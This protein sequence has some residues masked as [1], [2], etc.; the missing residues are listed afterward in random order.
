M[1]AVQAIQN[2]GMVKIAFYVIVA[3]IVIYYI[4]GWYSGSTNDLVLSNTKIPANQSTTAV[5]STGGSP[6]IRSGGA[7]TLS[8]W[9]YINSYEY[10][11]G[12]PK[13]VFTIYDSKMP[14]RALVV[15][16]LY[17][18]EPKMMIRFATGKPPGT[19]YTDLTTQ[20]NYL[21][22]ASILPSPDSN[23]IELPSCDVLEI[24]LQRWVNLT[25]SVNG[26][27]VDV[28]MDGKLT[29]SCVLSDLPLA[30]Q[31]GKQGITL[32]ALASL[33]S[34]FSGYFGTVKFSGR[35]LSPDQIYSF[36]Q[37]G[38]YPSADMGFLGF[39]ATKIGIKLQYGGS[40][41]AEASSS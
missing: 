12:K 10:R 30:S 6:A 26:R 13:S 32:G 14:N 31:D 11:A 5:I 27:V 40:T 3:L 37:Q 33:Q 34:G 35:A 41:P 18:N 21:S 8:M 39:L 1:Q 28:Y 4:Y 24:D 16:L 25:L 20:T 29:R 23:P 15:G 17:P 19:D 2:N 7:Y 9:L 22:G 36:Y 38:P